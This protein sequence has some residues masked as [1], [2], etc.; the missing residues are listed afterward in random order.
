VGN[1][2]WSQQDVWEIWS[3]EFEGLYAE[4][5]FFNWLGH[6]QIIGRPARMRMVERLIQRIRDKGDVWWPRPIELARFWL[7]R[8]GAAST[9]R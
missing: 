8:S 6:P 9:I 1:G 5:S 4:G 2:I 3:E 7:E